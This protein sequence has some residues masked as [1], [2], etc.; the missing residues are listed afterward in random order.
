MALDLHHMLSTSVLRPAPIDSRRP[1]PVLIARMA[2]GSRE[3]EPDD[4][5]A[6]GKSAHGSRRTRIWEFDASLHCSIIGTCLTTAE[7]RHILDKLKIG[8]VASDHEV[9][10]LGVTLAGRREAGAKFLQKAL[11]RR[12]RAAI[13]RYSKANDPTALTALWAECCTRA[14]L[15]AIERYGVSIKCWQVASVPRHRSHA[16]RR[17]TEKPQ[18]VSSV[19][20]IAGSLARSRG[21]SGVRRA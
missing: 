16:Y 6:A 11:D 1:V 10:T 4:I 9:H 5:G 3:L 17:A 18:T 20:S 14:S 12:H 13:T 19:T 15:I 2:D 21:A 7:L 8:N